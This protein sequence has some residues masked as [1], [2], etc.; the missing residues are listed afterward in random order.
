MSESLYLTEHDSVVLQGT[1]LVTG[2][3]DVPP[4]NRGMLITSLRIEQAGNS[5]FTEFLAATWRAMI[6]RASAQFVAG[7]NESFA[8]NSLPDITDRMDPRL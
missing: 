5:T 1:P 8:R 2:I 7:F 6:F 4:F 3:V